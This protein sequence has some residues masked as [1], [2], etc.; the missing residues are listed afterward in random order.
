MT[1]FG[2]SHVFSSQ[3][4][5]PLHWPALGEVLKVPAA[6]A[7][8]LCL[9]SAAMAS[10]SSPPSGGSS[11]GASP[12]GSSTSGSSLF[13][14]P[15]AQLRYEAYSRLQAAAVAFGES[16]RRA[17]CWGADDER[18]ADRAQAAAA[19][20][21][22]SPVHV[23]LTTPHCS[24]TPAHSTRP[25]LS[26]PVSAGCPSPKLWPSAASRTARARCWRRSWASASTCAR[27]RWERAGVRDSVCD[28]SMCTCVACSVCAPAV[29][30]RLLC[31]CVCSLCVHAV[32]AV[33]A[34][35]MTLITAP[36]ARHPQ[37]TLA[38]PPRARRTAAGRSSFRWCTT[39]RRWSRA[40][41]CRTRTARSTGRPSRQ[42][43]LSRT[44]S[45]RARS[46]TSRSSATR[47][48]RPSPS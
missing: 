34:H 36:A 29:C 38:T 9:R 45:W 32:C 22:A 27:W 19:S 13:D 11:G 42:R 31:V 20:A 43:R 18:G 41:A 2:L 4:S 24:Q 5:T 6:A 16:C 46:S 26:H 1:A 47:R 3:L 17:G 37:R 15:E 35:C 14:S 25:R 30:L 21:S 12:P 7:A 8:G 28:R 33:A 40:A 39:L 48:C 10:S 23:L 44:R